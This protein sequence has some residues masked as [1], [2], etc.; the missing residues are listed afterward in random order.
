M[1]NETSQ[2]TQALLRVQEKLEAVK[3]T[4]ANPYYKSKYANL[5]SVLS[6]VK[7]LLEENK[8]L[9]LQPCGRDTQGSFVATEVRHL[10][11]EAVQCRVYFPEPADMQ[12]LG[13]SITYGRRFG[14]TSL[15][16]MEQEDDDGETAVGRGELLKKIQQLD[17]VKAKMA[18]TY[19][20]KAGNDPT[21]LKKINS[22]VEALLQ[23]RK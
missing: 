18:E 1:E 22:R 2:L 20:D 12:K 16:A 23:E 11:G 21:E 3:K 19:L 10:N 8:L 4:S 17:P 5:E 7:P 6:I 13:A 9:L 14:L 15:F